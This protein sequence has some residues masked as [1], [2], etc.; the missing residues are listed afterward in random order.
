[1]DCA[2]A[3]VQAG[4]REVVLDA[5]RVASYSSAFYDEQFKTARELLAEG[6]VA[7]RAFLYPRT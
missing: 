6:G 7:L 4:I 2:R 1:M 5:D 3:I